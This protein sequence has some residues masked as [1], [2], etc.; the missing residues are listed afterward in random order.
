MIFV[1][2]NSNYKTDFD[3]AKKYNA[4]QSVLFLLKNGRTPVFNKSFLM[5]TV[6]S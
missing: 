1:I 6:Y 5:S 3:L 4:A 2:H